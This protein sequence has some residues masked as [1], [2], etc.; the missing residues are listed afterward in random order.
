MNVLFICKANRDRSK[1]AENHF[2]LTKPEHEYKSCGTTKYY[3][4]LLGT[5]FINKELLGWADI[6]YCLDSEHPKY[7]E[8]NFKDE[9]DNKTVFLNIEDIYIYMAPKLIE[10]LNNLI[11]L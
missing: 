2:R 10:I 11:I 9:S 4:E 1:T 3:C 8:D 7:F 6:V 5:Q